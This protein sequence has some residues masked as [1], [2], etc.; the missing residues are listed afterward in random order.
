MNLE[1]AR[2]C[3]STVAS[4]CEARRVQLPESPKGL[5]QSIHRILLGAHGADRLASS[6]SAI[7][8]LLNLKV[9]GQQD[10][11]LA[12]L[13][14]GP[15]MD[16]NQSKDEFLV[17]ADGSLLSFTIAVSF[18]TNDY[19]RLHFHRYHLRRASG[20]PEFLRF[21][22]NTPGAVHDALSGTRSHLHV[23]DE[24][25]RITIPLMTPDEI[26]SKVLFGLP[27]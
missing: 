25:I 20:A 23:S 26:L 24:D 22:L 4:D 11:Q 14:C 13:V 18:P 17:L 9:D 27:N 5:R 12:T 2:L 19:A 7:W 10:G 1:M 6:L 15:P 3:C 16:K 8:K 21:D